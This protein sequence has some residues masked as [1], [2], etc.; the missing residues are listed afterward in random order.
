MLDTTLLCDALIVTNNL[1]GWRIRAEREGLEL[2]KSW[3]FHMCMKRIV[4]LSL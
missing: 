4:R 2:P 1:T 3:S